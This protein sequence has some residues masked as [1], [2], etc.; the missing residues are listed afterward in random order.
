MKAFRVNSIRHRPTP[1][2]RCRQRASALELLD[3]W[4]GPEVPFSNAEK[5]R[6][7]REAMFADVDALQKSGTLKIPR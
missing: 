1:S 7:M 3:K 6:Q 2:A 4:L 5:I